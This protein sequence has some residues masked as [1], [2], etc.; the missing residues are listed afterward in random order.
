MGLHMARMSSRVCEVTY[1]ESSILFGVLLIVLFVP[2]ALSAQGKRTPL[3]V[4]TSV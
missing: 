3:A 2:L 1:E 4:W